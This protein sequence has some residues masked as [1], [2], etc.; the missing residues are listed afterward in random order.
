MKKT[1]I[2]LSIV[3]ILSGYLFAQWEQ[4]ELYQRI[5]QFQSQLNQ[6]QS[7]TSRYDNERVYE[8]LTQ[9]KNWYERARGSWQDRKYRI[10]RE[11]FKTAV[12]LY[13]QASRLLFLKPVLN[14]QNT[15]DETIHKAEINLQ[16]NES[17]DGR[18]LLNK[19][20]E[21]KLKADRQI[22]LS[23]YLKGQE[24]LR[25]ALHFAQ[26]AFDLSEKA[27]GNAGERY[28]YEEELQ[29][30]Q[31][32]Y[33]ELYRL[34]SNNRQVSELLQKADSYIKESQN[35]FR[36][37]DKRQAFYQ[38]KIAEKFLFRAVD[39][40]EKSSESRPQRFINNLN[41]MRQFLHGIELSIN[42]NDNPAARKFYNKAKN[43]LIE[44]ENDHQNGE[45]DKAGTKLLLAQRLGNR[46]LNLIEP[47]GERKIFRIENRIDEIDRII[48]L[49]K[50]KIE[51]NDDI[52][53]ENLHKEAERLLKQAR[54]NLENGHEN[55]AFQTVQLTL[56]LV[57][58]IDLLM[59]KEDLKSQSLAGL[60]KEIQNLENKLNT[61]HNS[62]DDS[63]KLQTRIQ[64]LKNLLQ[65]AKNHYENNELE[66]SLELVR[67]VQS[68]LKLI[69]E[70]ARE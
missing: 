10:A 32:L 31:D 70:K 16:K 64:I 57:N 60:N 39:L 56:R 13:R 4:D 38:L 23:N 49:Q 11:Q 53:I 48:Q 59:H 9:A 52:V 63:E 65:N 47:I 46:V 62:F 58:R 24:Y 36:N 1:I 40:S 42:N 18:Y 27:G 35:T 26:K 68:Q 54:R 55:Q 15:L 28:N 66:T 14:I 45:L 21:F 50:Q 44:A 7:L 34:N 33:R 22:N 19:A 3:L 17:R 5:R 37:N 67:I 6:L 69:L 51:N 25:I 61:I 30:L 8:I 29:N 2:I 41:S 43:L 12:I 20:R